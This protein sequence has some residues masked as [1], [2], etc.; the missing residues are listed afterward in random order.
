MAINSELLFVASKGTKWTVRKDPSLYLW[1]VGSPYLQR[2]REPGDAPVWG[3][4]RL[5]NAATQA[6]LNEIK[7]LGARADGE[8]VIDWTRSINQ[9]QVP[10]VLR[11]QT[12]QW[13]SA[14]RAYKTRTRKARATVVVDAEIEEIGEAGDILSSAAALIDFDDL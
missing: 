3:Q 9:N 10:S 7:E 4:I 6:H 13:L 2:L 1:V 14:E 8:R 12:D 11:T 5:Q